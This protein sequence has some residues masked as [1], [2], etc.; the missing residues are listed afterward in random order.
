MKKMK[1]F[2]VL[3]TLLFAIPVCAQT[4]S[5]KEE[6]LKR[7]AKEKVGQFCDYVSFIASKKKSL[8]TR[9]YYVDKAKNLFLN[10]GA[11]LYDDDGSLVRDSIIMQVTSLKA[12][13]PR[14]V[15]MNQYLPKL[16]NLKYP[17]VEVTSTDVAEMK[18]SNLEKV[19]ARLYTCTVY[20]YQYFIGK[21]GDN[22]VRY[23]DKTNK[24]VQCYI[25]EQDTEDGYEYIVLLGDIY[26]D[27]TESF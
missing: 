17:Q 25:I 10:R 27:T 13:K 1:L 26:A 24:R 20:F 19:G 14:N 12:K 22:N 9:Y 8:K 4:D 3:L 6:M 16:A 2:T 21:T 7:R 15:Y 5:Q 18:V 11:A 23:K